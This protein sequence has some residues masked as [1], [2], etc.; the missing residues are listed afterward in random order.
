MHISCW[1]G[2]VCDALRGAMWAREEAVCVVSLS[3]RNAHTKVHT[4]QPITQ[5]R[6]ADF[7]KRHR[8]PLLCDLPHPLPPQTLS[9][10]EVLIDTSRSRLSK[11]RL[12]SEGA[13]T[14]ARVRALSRRHQEHHAACGELHGHSA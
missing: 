4:M 3:D 9:E 8:G 2:V 14:M 12:R 11:A 5:H 6:S 7:M 10:R 13:S 1:V